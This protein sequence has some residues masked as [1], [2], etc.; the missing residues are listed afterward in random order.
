MNFAREPRR[1]PCS[2]D[3]RRARDRPPRSPRL[4]DGHVELE[5]MSGALIA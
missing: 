5:P 3:V 4:V 2:G 1:V